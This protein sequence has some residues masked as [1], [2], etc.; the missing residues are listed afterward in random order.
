MMEIEHVKISSI[1]NEAIILA[2]GRRKS[3]KSV[4]IMS[5]LAAKKNEFAF[6]VCF[7][8]STA[9]RMDY[10]KIMP[11]RFIYD[12]VDIKVLERLV[13]MQEAAV[14]KGNAKN[15]F[16]VCDDCGY[17]SRVFRSKIFRRLFQ[18]GRHAKIFFILSL[19]YSLGIKPALRG[20]VDFV[21][22]SLEKNPSFRKKLF[23]H[24]GIAVRSFRAF[25]KIMVECTKNYETLVLAVAS[26]N[27]VKVSDNFYYYK[28][29]FP[30]PKFKMVP[31]GQWWKP[32]DE[33]K[34]PPPPPPRATK[35]LAL[36]EI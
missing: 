17:D 18:N 34:K 10:E 23:E 35:V 6:G 15:V 7:C 3:G 31:N 20:Q 2:L 4:N 21:F 33:R 8:G 26:K 13:D 29:Q 28:S 12:G 25:D 30:I 19:Q 36:V 24:Y 5:L 16:V 27:S 11:R 22:A 1:P 9:T 14:R 32:K